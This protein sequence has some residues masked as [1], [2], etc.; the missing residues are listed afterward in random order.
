MNTF[1]SNTDFFIA[2]E[3]LLEKYSEKY[4]LD[5]Q[6]VED[7]KILHMLCDVWNDGY[8]KGF[9]KG[10]EEGYEYVRTVMRAPRN[11]PPTVTQKGAVFC[12]RET[13]RE[14]ESC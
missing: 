9:E 3:R 2:M 13:K 5:S 14:L 11:N 7:R 6:R 4:E 8:K 12:E 10:F 1:R